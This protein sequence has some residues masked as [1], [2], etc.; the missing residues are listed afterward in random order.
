M[1]QAPLEQWVINRINQLRHEQNLSQSMIAKRLA[2]LRTAVRTYL[3]PLAQWTEEK[4]IKQYEA[5]VNS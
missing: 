3:M 5:R 4:K 1:G 2:I